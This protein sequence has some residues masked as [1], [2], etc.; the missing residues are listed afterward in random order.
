LQQECSSSEP[1][2][3][4]FARYGGDQRKVQL[5]DS[6]QPSKLS[7]SHLASTNVEEALVI[8][9]GERVYG[10]TKL[11]A[12]FDALVNQGCPVGEMLRNV[13]LR[14][15]EVHS[16]KARVSLAELI[17]ACKNAIRLSSDRHLPYRELFART[18]PDRERLRLYRDDRNCLER[19]PRPQ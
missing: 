9:M 14:E 19:C 2:H 6:G 10:S 16:P 7:G 1:W 11:A 17:T 5:R 13:N 4:R 15:E 12:L 18:A 3:A 8:G